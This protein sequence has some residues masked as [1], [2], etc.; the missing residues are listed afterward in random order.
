MAVEN[1]TLV[2]V[3]HEP[4]RQQATVTRGK[5]SSG[6]TLLLSGVVVHAL[7]ITAPV[8]RGDVV[9]VITETSFGLLTREINLTTSG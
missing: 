7:S 5:V 3:C 1:T 6:Q 8:V 2:L 9:T 4:G